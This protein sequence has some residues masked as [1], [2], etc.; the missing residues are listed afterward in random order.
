M[1]APENGGP[2]FPTAPNTQPGV[3]VH[4]GMTLRDWFAGQA[5]ATMKLNNSWSDNPLYWEGVARSAYVAA[6]TMLAV[7][8]MDDAAL[9]TARKAGELSW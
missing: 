4:H 2:A 3:Y 5:L 7:R 1:S 6:D 8:S 9:A